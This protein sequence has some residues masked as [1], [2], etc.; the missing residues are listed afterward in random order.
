MDER[1][2][3]QDR[4]RTAWR[5]QAAISTTAATPTHTIS[6]CA[7]HAAPDEAPVP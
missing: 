7:A 1:E 3:D 5:T 4:I 2:F 6:I